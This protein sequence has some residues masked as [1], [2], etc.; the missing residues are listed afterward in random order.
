VFDNQV[1][2]TSKEEGEIDYYYIV[3]GERKDVEKLEVE[4]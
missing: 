1:I 3:Y 2:V 4:I